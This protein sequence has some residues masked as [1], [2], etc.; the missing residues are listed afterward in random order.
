MKHAHGTKENIFWFII[1]CFVATN[2]LLTWK[3]IIVMISG[4]FCWHCA[5]CLFLFLS[6]CY[7]DD[8]YGDVL[9]CFYIWKVGPILIWSPFK[10]GNFILCFCHS[11]IYFLCYRAY[12]G[13]ECNFLHEQ[14]IT[15]G[16]CKQNSPHE[17]TWLLIMVKLKKKVIMLEFFDKLWDQYVQTITWWFSNNTFMY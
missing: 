8:D 1:P 6:N 5:F 2:T 3:A 17:F 9:I 15:G 16:Y 14:N 10:N 12:L 11:S 7:F 4:C 13:S